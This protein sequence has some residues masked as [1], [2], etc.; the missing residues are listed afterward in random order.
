[1]ADEMLLHVKNIIVIE[2]D[3]K[4]KICRVCHGTGLVYGDDDMYALES[5][6]VQCKA[7]AGSGRVRKFRVECICSLP[8]DYPSGG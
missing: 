4:V 8:H 5:E 1:M 3:F 2:R 7:C 6:R